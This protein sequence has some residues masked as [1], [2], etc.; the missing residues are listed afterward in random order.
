MYCESHA[1]STVM[2]DDI[3]MLLT[4]HIYAENIEIMGMQLKCTTTTWLGYA[5]TGLYK[6]YVGK[7]V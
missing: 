2:H 6:V 7:E 5:R 3:I 4:E 1:N